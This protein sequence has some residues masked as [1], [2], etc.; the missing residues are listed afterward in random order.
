VS[1]L[2]SFCV[3][4]TLTTFHLELSLFVLEC[5]NSR[6]HQHKAPGSPGSPGF[7]TISGVSAVSSNLSALTLASDAT[8]VSQYTP[9]EYERTSYY[10]GITRDGD[11][12]E[13]VYR[14]DFLTTLFPKPVG[15]HAHIPVK[16]LHG[17]FDT[18]L[19]GVWDTVGPEIRDLIKARKINWSSVDPAR[20]FTHG[21]LGEE[22]KGSLGPV[23]IW[24]GVIPGSTSSGTA[25]EVSQEIL[26]LLLKNG[27]EDAVVEWREAVLQRLAGPPLMR[28]VG[29]NNATHYVR[30]FLTALLGIPLA[31]EGMEEEDAQPEGT[32]TLWFHE[33][34]DKDGNPS[35]KIYGVSNCHVLRKDTT[36]EYEHRGGAPKDHVRVCGM[37]R[38]Q[39]GLN[40]IRKVIGD[41]GILADLWARE[42]VELEAK[43]RKDAENARSIRANRRKLEDEN[44]A[45]ADLEAL[46]DE[47]TEYWSDSKFH[48]NIGHVRYAAA[49][50]AD[51][52]GGTL[53]TSNWA[54]FLAAEA[55]VKDEFEGNVVD[56]GAFRSFSYL[57]RLTK[58]TLFRI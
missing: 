32:L 50:T 25:H 43:E 44:E 24:V 28:H 31:T 33:N 55:K 49:I 57:P 3:Y 20:F 41:H 17:V 16:S 53:Y 22:E 11:H 8:V 39:R 14:S 21:P 40:E 10:N 15:R 4:T 7:P 46:Y 13:L 26:A 30:R 51:V 54:A 6:G 45:I 42:I 5:I 37:H 36:V 34:K 18:P 9:D 12:P 29:S 23:V 58:T 38:F 2:I 35:D 47:V 48:R 56:L 19:N 27:V 1:P 52:E